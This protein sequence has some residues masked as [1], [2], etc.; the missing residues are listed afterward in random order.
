MERRRSSNSSRTRKRSSQKLQVAEP[1]QVALSKALAVKY[2]PQKITHL[3]GQ[4]HVVTQ[5]KGMHKR[6]EYPGAFLLEGQTGGGKTTVARIIHGMLNCEQ[7]TICGKCAS[8]QMGASHPDLMN[9]NAGKD[10]KVDDIRNLIKSAEV[11]PMFNKRVIVID[12]AHKLTGAAAEALLVP[13]E[14]PKANTVWILCTTNPEKVLPTIRS[15]CTKLSMKPIE[16]DAIIKRLMTIA[17]REGYDLSQISDAEETFELIAD[18]SNGSMRE[19]ISLLESVLYAIAGGADFTKENVLKSFVENTEIDLDKV[20]VS[21]VA[22]SLNNDP[23]NA[24]KA[25]MKSTNPRGVVS[26]SRWLIDYLTRNLLKC[27]KFTPY[28]GRLFESIAQKDGIKIK[29]SDLLMLQ[30]TIVDAEMKMNTTSI[31]EGIILQT[32]ITEFFFS[33][34][35]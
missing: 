4:P 15:R 19:A 20:A 9:V 8:C 32:A 6:G 18:F 24:I 22:A 13:I 3:V 26:K 12:E 21:L 11:A 27:A 23:K 17:K 31:D 5:I 29:L 16:P 35:E 1:K 34:T 10:G 30:K 33:Q 25:I 14:E 7:G 28:S 2:R